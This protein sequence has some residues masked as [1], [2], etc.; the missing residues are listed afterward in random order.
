M[1]DVRIGAAAGE[2]PEVLYNRRPTT[3]EGRVEMAFTVPA[4]IAATRTVE[5]SGVDCTRVVFTLPPER[6]PLTFGPVDPVVFAVRVEDTSGAIVGSIVGFGCHPVSIYPSLST[7]ISADYPAFA[8]RVVEQVE[9]GVSL[10]TLGLA[11]NTVPLQRGARPCAQMGRAVGAEALKRLQLAATTGEVT[12]KAL[13]REVIFP[14]KKAPATDGIEV[15]TADSITTEIQVLKLG[16]I[17]VLGL[18]GEVLVEVG[19]AVKERAGGMNLLVVTCAN[20]AIGYVCLREAYERG[21]YEPDS[22]TD[23]AP[24]AGEIMVAESLALLEELGQDSL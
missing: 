8:T 17:Y 1:R 14:I 20:D 5:T 16:D 11:G 15:Q 23:L 10:F 13:S 3:N 6:K 19:L 4:E 22:G 21:G 9:G 18:P 7:T 24:G 12:L 2:L